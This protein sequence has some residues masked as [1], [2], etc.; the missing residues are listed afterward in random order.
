MLGMREA[1]NPRD[2]CRVVSW[3]HRLQTSVKSVKVCD[4]AP[5]PGESY[6]RPTAVAGTTGPKSEGQVART[7]L[8]AASRVS[9]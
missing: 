3:G 8:E 2:L 6:S 5:G 7:S 1:S 9:M 4:G